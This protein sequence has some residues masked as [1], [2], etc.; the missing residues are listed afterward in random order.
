M[1]DRFPKVS[2]NGL[3]AGLCLAGLATAGLCYVNIMPAIVNGLIEGLGFTNQQAGYVASANTYSA[4]FGA[5]LLVGVLVVFVRLGHRYL[6]HR[7]CRPP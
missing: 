1:Y 4:A 5:L 7:R 2:P 3:T 6:R